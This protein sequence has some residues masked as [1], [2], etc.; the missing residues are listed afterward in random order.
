MNLPKSRP[1]SMPDIRAAAERLLDPKDY[2]DDPMDDAHTV[3]RAWLEDHP[4]D[5][6]LPNGQPLVRDNG[7]VDVDV[8]A[9]E[10]IQLLM[11]IRDVLLEATRRP[12][13]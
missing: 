13:K 6:V 3:A 10:V 4:T 9:V 11:E 2:S 1:M 8:A 5:W 7:R 12:D